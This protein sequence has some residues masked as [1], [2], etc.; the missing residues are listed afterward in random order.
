MKNYF[1]AKNSFVAEV[2][3]IS[4]IINYYFIIDFFK[5]IGKNKNKLRT[6]YHFIDSFQEKSVNYQELFIRSS[7][8]KFWEFFPL[9]ILSFSQGTKLAEVVTFSYSRLE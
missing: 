9:L 2:T 5:K 4:G 7:F 8:G 3:S 1:I 6:I